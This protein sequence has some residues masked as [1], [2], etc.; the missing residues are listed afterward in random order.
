MNNKTTIESATAEIEE[1]IGSSLQLSFSQATEKNHDTLA[2]LE[3]R[4]VLW[5]LFR[6]RIEKEAAARMDRLAELSKEARGVRERAGKALKR[7]VR[8]RGL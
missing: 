3:K 1:E 8:I 2:Q 6:P 4:F 5:R 7:S